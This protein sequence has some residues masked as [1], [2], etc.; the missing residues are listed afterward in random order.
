MKDFKR[1]LKNFFLKKEYRDFDPADNLESTVYG[2]P[3]GDVRPAAERRDFDPERNEVRMLYGPPSVLSRPTADR[4]G[5][6]PV[7]KPE[8]TVNAPPS[9]FTRPSPDD[10]LDFAPQNNAATDLYG[11]P[12]FEDYELTVRRKSGTEPKLSEEDTLH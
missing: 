5:F 10:D 1:K 8:R 11:P 7:G 2:P 4:R 6:N 9:F 12:P 3:T